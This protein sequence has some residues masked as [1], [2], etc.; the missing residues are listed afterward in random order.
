MAA[1]E[2]QE[3]L[4]AIQHASEHKPPAGYLKLVAYDLQGDSG[5]PSLASPEGQRA[6]EEHLHDGVELLILDN[7]SCLFDL[8]END[9]DQWK[10]RAQPWLMS[11]RRRGVAVLF[12]HHAG[13]S[14]QQRGTGAREDVLDYVIRLKHP[15]D[16]RHGAPARFIVSFEKTRGLY[17][18]KTVP[19][20]A[21]LQTTGEGAAV[22]TCRPSRD[23][24]RALALELLASGR[25]VTEVARQIGAHKSSVSRWSKQS[26]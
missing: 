10:Q 4:R 6:I 24:Q 26:G 16:Y 11:L 2:L 3:R 22:W 13:K 12:M 17:R 5:L 14:G 19:F 23:S 15:P 9:A 18:G 1:S 25:T 8:P 20:E 7:L 21:G